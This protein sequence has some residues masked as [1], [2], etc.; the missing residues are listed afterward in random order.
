MAAHVSVAI[1][2]NPGSRQLRDSRAGAARRDQKDDHQHRRVGFD[3]QR[4]IPERS[5]SNAALPHGT[6]RQSAPHVIIHRSASHHHRTVR[7][8]VTPGRNEAHRN[9]GEPSP[10]T[11]F[12]YCVASSTSNW[13]EITRRYGIHQSL[14]SAHRPPPSRQQQLHRRARKLMRCCNGTRQARTQLPPPS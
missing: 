14:P 3:D 12:L 9:S 8:H 6:C 10:T 7:A 4:G 11:H 13:A 5:P 2:A 1:R